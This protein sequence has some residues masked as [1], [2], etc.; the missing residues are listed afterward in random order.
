MP[1]CDRKETTRWPARTQ[2]S[3]PQ[4]GNSAGIPHPD[5]AA[6]KTRQQAAWSSGNYAIV[7]TTLQIV[8]EQLCEALD[9]QVRLEGARCRRRQRH[10]DSGCGTALVRGHL[11]RLCAGLLDRGR[12]RAAAEG[13]D[14]RIQGSRRR[15]LPFDDDSFR[16][17]GLHLRR[18]VHAEPGPRR[19]RAAAG[20]QAER[21][22][23]PRQLDAG[24]LHRPGLQDAGQISAAACRHQIAGAVGHAPRS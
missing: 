1:L 13:H 15:N 20:L 22:D 23:R 12:A 24:R 17:R 16:R 11:D 18:D 19:R 14:D 9:L 10:G 5:L 21:Q 6:L 2:P 8:G 4:S 7:G 3:R